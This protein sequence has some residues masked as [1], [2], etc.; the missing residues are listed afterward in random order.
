MG[1]ESTPKRSTLNQIA[2][3]TVTP[4]PELGQQVTLTFAP[5]GMP[6]T[7]EIAARGTSLQRRDSS[8]LRTDARRTAEYLASRGPTPVEALHDIARMKFADAVR[9]I[10]RDAK[11]T[12]WQAANFWKDCVVSLLPY[13]AAKFDSLDLSALLGGGAAG[14]LAVAHFLATTL[15]GERMGNATRDPSPTG[16]VID[17]AESRDVAWSGEGVTGELPLGALPAKPDD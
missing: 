3:P 10:A 8:A 6:Q 14:G 11:C 17:N 7:A 2:D 1:D 5:D 9:E 12:R 13:S 4:R 15:I 16:E